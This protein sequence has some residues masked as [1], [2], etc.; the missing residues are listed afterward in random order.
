MKGGEIMKYKLLSETKEYF[1]VT[2]HR[3]EATADF[4]DVEKGEKGGFIEKDENL[5]K[6]GNA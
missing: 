2:L 4:G 5:S 1:G 6:E 3:I